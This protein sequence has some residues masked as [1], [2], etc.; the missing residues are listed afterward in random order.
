MNSEK[1][2]SR[3]NFISLSSFG[4]AFGIKDLSG[5][6]QG[7]KIVPAGSSRSELHFINSSPGKNRVLK[8]HPEDNVAVALEDLAGGAKVYV[9][10]QLFVLK[11]NVPVKHKFTLT[12]INEGNPVYLYGIKVGI[13]LSDIPQ[14]AA[15][16]TVNTANATSEIKKKSLRN[17]K[18]YPPVTDGFTNRTFMGYHRPDGQV[19][20]AN[21]WLVIPMVF[22]E[23]RIVEIIRDAVMPELGYQKNSRY[24]HFVGELA[25]LYK[26]GASRDEIDRTGIKKVQYEND[27]ENLFRN[28]TGIRFL[29]H[30]GGCGGTRQDAESL[31]GLLAGYITHPNVAGATVLSLGCQN[32]QLSV[33]HQEISKRDANF[34]KPLYEFEHQEI[35]TEE[36]LVKRAIKSIFEGMSIADRAER[37]PAPLSKLCIG[38][39]CGGSDGFSGISANPAIG[40]VSDLI[41]AL[42][43]SAVLSEFPEL[44]GVEQDLYDRCVNQDDADLFLNLMKNYDSLAHH[45]GSGFDKNPSPGN[46]KDGLITDAMKS[47]GASKKGGTSPVAGVLDY[48]GK[49]TGNGLHLLCTPG[50]DV[51]SVTAE[52]ASGANIVLF[53]TGL[54]TPTGNP[55]V[56]VIKIS[57]NTK[58]FEKMPDIMDINAGTIIDGIESIEE[59]AKRI[60]DYVIDTASGI[61]EPAAVR[62][63][64]ADFIPWKRGVSL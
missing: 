53:T 37:K 25:H 41:V 20:T 39:E 17:Y 49:I 34:S 5:K 16:T 21:Y 23:N 8:L 61:K 11:E 50:N 22:C 24:G 4:M 40:H 64:Q 62:D 30:S 28:V 33:L 36:E 59:T 7:K 10:N 60:L 42:G 3:R 19:G 38:L 15:I 57:T 32:A 6:E 2:Y 27:S 54:G 44:S 52:V 31:C 29:F 48:P 51:E 55:V 46:I 9:D 13:A 63:N 58:L 47:A 14:A 26:Q 12:E 35:G 56:P 1:K 18:W 43:G 45:V